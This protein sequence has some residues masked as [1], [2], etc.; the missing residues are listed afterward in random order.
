M[1][2]AGMTQGSQ[3][4]AFPQ[5]GDG[6]FIEHDD[7]IHREELQLAFRNKALPL[8]AL[9]YDITP[10]GM[11]Y[12]LIHYDIP[13]VDAGQWGL[14]VDNGEGVARTFSL[15]ELKA[16]PIRTVRVTMECA[17]DG[18]ALTHP[19]AISQPWLVG[20]VGTAEWEGT[21]VGAL[22]E[23]MGISPG[24][25]EVLFTGLDEGF[26]G[27]LRQRYQRS[28]PLEEAINDEDMILAWSMNGAPLEPQHGYPLRLVIPGWYGMAH[29]KW[30]SSIMLLSE[31]FRGYQQEV[32]YRFADSRDESGRPV[33]RMRVRSLMVPPGVPDYLT[34]TRVVERGIVP[35]YGRAWSGGHEIVRVGVSSD[36]GATWDESQLHPSTSAHDWQGWRYDWEA[37]MQ[38]TFELCCRA[39]DSSGDVQPLDQ[40]WTARGMGNNVV[41]R[42]AVMVV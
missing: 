2:Q 9:R 22:L 33:T 13:H 28:F 37:N 30:L 8:E 11:H 36:G 27:G 34:R 38:G 17:G 15:D 25:C 18:R 40:Y 31:P 23:E 39:T 26:E 24:I 7:R 12:T 14:I 1:G 35:L 21:S 10:T 6:T 4:I 29:V 32:A 5:V 41:H 3:A 42:V 16:R 19:R 20:A